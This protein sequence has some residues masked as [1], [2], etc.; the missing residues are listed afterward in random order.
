MKSNQK[1]QKIFLKFNIIKGYLVIENNE[2]KYG[3]YLFY[4]ISSSGDLSM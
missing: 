1:W 4:N 3:D 2:L